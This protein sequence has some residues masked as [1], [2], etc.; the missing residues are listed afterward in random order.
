MPK[1]QLYFYH[2][3]NIYPFLLPVDIIHVICMLS[4][5]EKLELQNDMILELQKY[6]NVNELIR[7]R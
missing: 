6:V 7:E 1:P 2:R 4:K 5:T 3:I